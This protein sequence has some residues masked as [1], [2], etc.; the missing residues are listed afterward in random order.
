MDGGSADIAGA[1]VCPSIHGHIAFSALP[2]SMWVGWRKYNP[3]IWIA[4]P[5]SL[6]SFIIKMVKT[7]RRIAAWTKWQFLR[8]KQGKDIALMGSDKDQS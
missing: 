5:Y 1:N 8:G 6:I 2:A 3:K 7:A 4:S